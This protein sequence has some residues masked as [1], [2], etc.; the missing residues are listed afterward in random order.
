MD[1]KF[2]AFKVGQVVPRFVN[3]TEGTVFD[4]DGSGAVMKVFFNDPTPREIEQFKS[5]MRFEMRMVEVYGIIMLTAKI[6][7]LEWM[8]FPYSPHLSKNM[9][10]LENVSQGVGYAITLVLVNGKN[11]RVEHIRIIG[12][13]ERFSKEFKKIIEADTEK[14]F[15]KTEYDKNLKTLFLR[16]TTKQIADMSPYYFKIN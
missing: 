14:S 3:H 9:P 15:S 12:M 16:Y 8:D 1:E 5:S 13:T 11:G 7:N 6:G 10:V 2:Q 4:F